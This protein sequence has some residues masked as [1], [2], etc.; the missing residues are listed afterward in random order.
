M[1][2]FLTWWTTNI[3]RRVVLQIKSKIEVDVILWLHWKNVTKIQRNYWFGFCE[4]NNDTLHF[5]IKHD[6]NNIIIVVQYTI[7]NFVHF[8]LLTDIKI[9][10]ILNTHTR[11][12]DCRKTISNNPPCIVL[13][14]IWLTLIGRFFNVMFTCTQ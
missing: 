11:D 12:I 14:V 3:K 9:N 5:K 10:T 2:F 8:C 1:C 6:K 13:I 4:K 7:V